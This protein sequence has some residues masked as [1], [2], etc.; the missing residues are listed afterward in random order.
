MD[1]EIESS[2]VN[3]PLGYGSPA[4]EGD[5]IAGK[6]RVERLVG[7][8]GMGV[9]VAATHMQLGHLVAIKLLAPQF[10]SVPVAVERFLQEAR[11]AA[12]I[13]SDH[14]VRV[15]DVGVIDDGGP[16]M[17]MDY[18]EG[19]DLG[20]TIDRRGTLPVAETVECLLQACEGVAEAHAV[21]V[22]HRD[23]K[24]ANLV[25][26]ERPGAPPHVKVVDFGISKV[27]Q[28]ASHPPSDLSLTGPHEIMGSPLYAS[29][30]QIRSASDVDE[31]A[32]IWALGA[33]CY[34]ALAGRPPFLATT[35]PEL[36]ERVAHTPHASLQELRSDVPAL[37]AAVVDRCLAKD[38]AARFQ[39]VAELAAS[40]VSFAPARATGSIE[41]IA[42]ITRRMAPVVFLPT[43]RSRQGSSLAAVVPPR[44]R[45]RTGIATWSWAIGA[46]L[47]AAAIAAAAM[48]SRGEPSAD[49]GVT[50]GRIG[51]AAPQAVG[52]ASGLMAA[53]PESMPAVRLSDP[54]PA[55]APRAPTIAV[56]RPAASA[57]LVPT[58]P[59][60]RPPAPAL[61][62]PTDPA[63]ATPSASSLPTVPA[64]PTPSASSAPA[65]PPRA[66]A[67]AA[68]GPSGTAGFG[69]LL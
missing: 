26:C 60:E 48:A 2:T 16:Y 42:S 47:V 9:V 65:K 18:L 52:A 36:Y 4:V 27:R 23:I 61:P 20:R 68:K 56:E 55:A 12:R 67:Q 6:Y 11:A 24:P 69:G 8:G 3:T 37:L 40:L 54:S 41:R 62:V 50:S 13:R 1:V 45:R 43:L 30:E 57:S 66:P 21:G 10:A 33:V 14:V 31:R 19:V 5:I 39:S 32:D 7:A 25:R 44:A 59:A 46:A 29:P 58:A 34:T 53:A 17:A 51:I 28:P 63:R 35:L 38:R 49:R 22:V 64:R 15:F